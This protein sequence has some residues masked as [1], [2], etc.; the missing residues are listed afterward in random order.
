MCA[1]VCLFLR[2][3]ACFVFATRL[4]GGTPRDPSGSG[5]A[6]SM[7]QASL[8]LFG[9]CISSCT[10]LIFFVSSLVLF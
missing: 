4:N 7:R 9:C 2:S 5:G 3:S 10:D 8:I 6:S 1:R